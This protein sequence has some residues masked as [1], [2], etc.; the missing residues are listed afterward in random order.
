MIR[1]YYQ[2]SI[3]QFLTENPTR[4]LGELAN[5]HAFDLEEQ[6]KQAWKVQIS[7][8]QSLLLEIDGHIYF[9]FSIPRMGK[10][11]DVVL[12]SKGIIFVLEFKVGEKGYTPH[13]LEQVMDYALDLKNFHATSHAI[14]IVPILVATHAKAHPNT[15]T[16]YQDQVYQTLR[17][18]QST[19]C[20]VLADCLQTISG[21]FIS[22]SEWESGQYKPTPT[23][24]EAAQALYRGHNVSDIS[25]SDG[26]AIN[27][28][29][30]TDA[31]DQII[32][33]AQQ[34]HQKVICFVTGVPG[35]GKTLA[36]LNIANRRLQ[37]GDDEHTVFLSGNGPLVNVL[38]EAR[39]EMRSLKARLKTSYS[40]R[41]TTQSRSF[42]SEH[43][44]LP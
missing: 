6:Q 44:F 16:P 8:L 2:S 14:P 35:A 23:I 21:P 22:P 17:V 41:L 32:T 38:R 31:I 40:K 30:T 42:Y 12:L 1:A 43:S 27:L 5:F 28:S 10:R 15:L 13:G 39:C 3:H 18:N 7:L 25:R 20:D 19:L 36:G 26:G 11:V 24:I 9:E 4:I 37:N 33:D 34:N 29:L